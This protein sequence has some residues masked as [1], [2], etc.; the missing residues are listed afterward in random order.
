MAKSFETHFK[1]LCK[2]IPD[3]KFKHFNDAL[4]CWVYSKAHY[5]ALLKER[6]MA[7]MDMIEE[8]AEGWEKKNTNKKYEMTAKGRDLIRKMKDIAHDNNGY[9]KYSDYPK[10]VEEL[11]TMGVHLDLDIEAFK[12]EAEQ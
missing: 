8:L 6:R 4:G 10:I 11:R 7:P 12:T 9:I 5:K 3:H 2:G 1:N